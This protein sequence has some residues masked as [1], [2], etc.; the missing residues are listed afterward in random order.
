VLWACLAVQACAGTGQTNTT[1]AAGRDGEATAP[2]NVILV[3]TDDQGY[4]DLA[5]H[6]NPTVTTPHLDRLYG[7]SVRFTDFHVSPMCSPTRA[8]LLTGRHARHVGVHGTNNSTNLIVRGVPT[9]ANVFAASGYRTG[10]FG[11][12]HLG[13]HYPY[14]P[15]DRGFD[16]SVVHG[17][18]A[19]T[20]IGDVWGNDYYDDTYLHNGEREKYT[21]YCTDVFFDKSLEFIDKNRSR[22]FFVYLATNTPHGPFL[23]PEE[24][25]RPYAEKGVPPWLDLFYGMITNI[26]ANM[27]RLVAKLRDWELEENTILIFMTDNGTPISHLLRQD[28]KDNWTVFNAGMRGEKT[29]PYDGGHR[30]PFFVRWPARGISGGRDVDHLA[31][32]LDV[33]PTFI[34][35]CGLKKPQGL[36]LD[37]MSL[38]PLLGRSP[39]PWP[40]R[41][42]VE[43]FGG[44]VMTQRWRLVHSTELYDI[45]A[46]PEQRND[47]AS[48]HPK[49]VSRLQA[50]LARNRARNELRKQPIVLGSDQQPSCELNPEHWRDVPRSFSKQRVLEGESMNGRLLVEIERPGL[51]EFSLRR[52]PR[53][54]DTPI[55]AAIPGGKALKV[56]R[57]RLKIR[58][59]DRSQSVTGEMTAATFEVPL[60]PGE[61]TIETWFTTENG[62]SSGAYFLYVKRR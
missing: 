51:Y 13:E 7:E 15:M 11:K 45:E 50:V 40:D 57:A 46:D 19:I 44:F 62:A 26:D 56:V 6:G 20:S 24:Y 2:P 36:D 27:G 25:S 5:C 59:F 43:T 23:V 3:I 17:N 10:I 16:E 4:G 32:H 52:W 35:L 1:L 61:A 39:P 42:V 48:Q 9:M 49:V 34:E 41:T 58:D 28:R 12:W 47:V 8:A 33:L 21:G 53:E 38:T 29:D 60:E 22:P 55:R 14:R 30:V 31:T 37:G 54:L 18:G